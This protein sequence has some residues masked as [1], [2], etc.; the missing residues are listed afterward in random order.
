MTGS[1]IPLQIL[2][3]T[4]AFIYAS[5]S[6]VT[7]SALH[8]LLPDHLDPRDVLEALE[9]HCAEHFSESADCDRCLQHLTEFSISSTS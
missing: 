9:R 1:S 3:L 2:Q 8:P 6:P 7:P 4:K 5:N